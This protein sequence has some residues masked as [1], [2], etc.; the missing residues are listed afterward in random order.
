MNIGQLVEQ[1]ATQLAE[2]IRG[3]P[4]SGHHGH[5]G[6]PGEVG[7]SLPSGARADPLSMAGMKALNK[8]ERARVPSKEQ[9]EE[10]ILVLDDGTVIGAD[11]QGPTSVN[12]NP[13]TMVNALK[14]GPV[15]ITH[16]HPTDMPLSVGDVISSMWDGVEEVRAVTAS[17]IYRMKF[18]LTADF[19]RKSQFSGFV[20]GFLDR[21]EER[22]RQSFNFISMNLTDFPEVDSMESA[23]ELAARSVYSTFWENSA[24]RFPDV[25]ELYD[26][27]IRE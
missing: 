21:S 18:T 7:G 3:G 11:E 10:G 24:D 13:T 26:F 4:G 22:V 17:T 19:D 12:F 5:A 8:W 23:N 1:T 14:T 20:R 15:V 2:V 16:T 6:R 9:G 25:I 27:E